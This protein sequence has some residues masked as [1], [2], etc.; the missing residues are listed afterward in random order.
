MLKGKCLN[1][2]CVYFGWALEFPSYQMCSQCDTRLEIYYEDNF[3]NELPPLKIERYSID[4]DIDA[5]I[6]EKDLKEDAEES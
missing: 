4:K 1:C 2:G 6:Q 5:I 3:S